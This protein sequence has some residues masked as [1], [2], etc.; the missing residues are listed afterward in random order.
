MHSTSEV[1]FNIFFFRYN[2]MIL[3]LKKEKELSHLNLFDK[4]VNL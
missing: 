3:I 1:Y 4:E 2:D